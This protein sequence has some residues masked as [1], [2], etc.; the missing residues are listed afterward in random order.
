[1]ADAASTEAKR[2]VDRLRSHGADAV[3]F[4]PTAFPTAA[5]LAVR[6]TATG[7]CRSLL[8]TPDGAVDL[9]KVSSAWH[10]HHRPPIADDEITDPFARTVAEDASRALVESVWQSLDRSWLP[11]GRR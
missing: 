1:M 10:W 8:V 6:Y 7:G 9:E 2:V 4:D 3:W 5:E 11:H